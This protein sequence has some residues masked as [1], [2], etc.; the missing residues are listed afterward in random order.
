MSGKRV[1]EEVGEGDEE[2]SGVARGSRLKAAG[3]RRVSEAG[4]LV[5]GRGGVE[6]EGADGEER[7]YRELGRRGRGVGFFSKWQ[8][9]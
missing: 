3:S 4:G 1:F 9:G 7:Q 6:R 5:G 8:A 2:E